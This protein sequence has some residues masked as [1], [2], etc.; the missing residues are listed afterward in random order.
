[1]TTHM[2]TEGTRARSAQQIARQI[3]A[4][5]TT[6]ETGVGLESASVTL[7]AITEELTAALEIMADVA[8][9][10]TFP[11][12]EL[13]RQ[14][15]RALDGL[16]VAYQQPGQ[17]AVFAAAPVVLVARSSATARRH[18]GFHRT[19]DP[20]GPANHPRRPLPAGQRR[21][22]ADWKPDP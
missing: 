17:L 1:M 20:S 16:L 21:L 9:N 6:L 18:A 10:P 13:E 7:S 19:A 5:G 15:Q 8:R 14:R 22:G 12:K 11:A 2:L 4:L 3:E